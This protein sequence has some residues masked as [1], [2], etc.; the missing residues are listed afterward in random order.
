[1]LY[2][3]R[4]HQTKERRKERRVNKRISGGK[5]RKEKEVMSEEKIMCGGGMGFG[6]NNLKGLSSNVWG[7]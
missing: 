3:R 2:L 7:I 6:I 5:K 4:E 1:M